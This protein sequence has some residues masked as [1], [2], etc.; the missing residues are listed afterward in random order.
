LHFK[1]RFN[2]AQHFND[3]EEAAP[4]VGREHKIPRTHR[5]A[6]FDDD[7]SG[8]QNLTTKRPAEC[9]SSL[10]DLTARDGRQIS[11]SLSSSVASFSSE[12]SSS[13]FHSGVDW[14]SSSS[15][16]FK[17]RLPLQVTRSF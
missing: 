5:G 4:E 9:S 1:K 8:P 2:I 10:V 3:D 17:K 15:C 6:S 12:A 13:S 11:T 7:A 16:L 14:P